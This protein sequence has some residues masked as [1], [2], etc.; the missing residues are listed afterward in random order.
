M[1]ILSATR[2]LSGIDR[3]RN[4]NRTPCSIDGAPVHFIPPN[5]QQI[6]AGCDS[7]SGG[8]RHR[9]VEPVTFT[10]RPMRYG[11]SCRSL[12]FPISPKRSQVL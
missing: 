1:T 10:R 3:K 6:A 7:F 11:K 4:A 8:T 12:Q 2:P 5:A 9:I